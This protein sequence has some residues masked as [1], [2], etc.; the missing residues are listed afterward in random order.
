MNLPPKSTGTNHS[1]VETTSNNNPKDSLNRAAVEVETTSEQESTS[2]RGGVAGSA[3]PVT[4]FP[5][6]SSSSNPSRSSTADTKLGRWSPSLQTLLDQPPASLPMRAILA[7]MAFCAVFGAWAWFGTIEEVGKGTGRL[8]PDGKTYKVQPVEAGK[9]NLISVKEG[10]EVKAGQIVAEL[11]TEVAQ[12]EIDRL[13]ETLSSYQSELTQKQ[14]LLAQKE[15]EAD[16]RTEISAAEELAQ[17]SAIALAREKVTTTRQLIAQQKTEIE[18]Y[19]T[20]K[21]QLQPI[22]NTT[23]EYVSQL[24]D[25]LSSNRERLERLEKLQ[26]EGGISKEVVFQAEQEVKEIEQ[27]IT[28]TKMQEITSANETLFEADQ[29]LREL[30]SR[31]TE[32]QGTL[33][34]QNKDV[35]QL[36]AQ[37]DQKIAEAN[38]TKIQIQ[39]AVKQL[40]LEISQTQAKI[41]DTRS[42]IA[43]AETKLKN[44]SLKAPVDGIVLS[45]NVEN[46]GEVLEAGKTVAE[47]APNGVPLVLSTV[48]AD[49]EAG[50]IE[51]GMTVNV[52]L[53]A[54][55]YQDYGVISGEVTDI[56][57][58]TKS[59][60]KLGLVRVVEIKL[61]RDYVTDDNQQIK[62]KAGQTASA[63]IV[64]RRRRIADVL[65]DP[66]R[67]IANDGMDL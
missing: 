39:Q 23:Q 17:R 61:E 56:S 19:E 50:H 32:N 62:F 37:L 54:Y 67:Q 43:T 59:D 3:I 30:E 16:T 57:K 58:D 22:S 38:T 7:G 35:E 14:S 29:S 11:D 8:V 5:R 55:P 45:L 15:A 1:V 40:E 27:R 25:E 51:T 12:K 41:T 26:K 28:Q 53:D 47:I 6:P 52:K 44:N 13:K 10:Q 66:I 18:A 64:I 49:S 34:T 2:L 21:T 4:R 31:L 46:P 65:L 20:R 33:V 48:V 9:V 42:Q 24:N 36:E 63:E 60:E